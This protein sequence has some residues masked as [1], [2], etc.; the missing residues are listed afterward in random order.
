[1]R[2]Y[3]PWKSSQV[4]LTAARWLIEFCGYWRRQ[5]ELADAEAAVKNWE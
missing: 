3:Y 1:M 2:Q 4:D 5:E